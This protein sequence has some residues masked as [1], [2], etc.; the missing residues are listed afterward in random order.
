MRE[1]DKVLGNCGCQQLVQ[2]AGDRVR[3]RRK[4][5]EKIRARVF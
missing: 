3:K 5:W 1:K 4:K 2:E